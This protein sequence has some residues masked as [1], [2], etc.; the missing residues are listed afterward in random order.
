MSIFTLQLI[1][2]QVFCLFLCLS[3]S[4]SL[5]LYLSFSFC[6]LFLTLIISFSVHLTLSNIPYILKAFFFNVFL[7]PPL[8]SSLP[9]TFGVTSLPI[10]YILLEDVSLCTLTQIHTCFLC[11][12][13]FDVDPEHAFNSGSCS[14]IV[15]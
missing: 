6:S 2:I 10:K 5:F 14:T 9:G 8:F 12:T 3:V 4:L 7:F 1:T 13:G 11:P 15:L